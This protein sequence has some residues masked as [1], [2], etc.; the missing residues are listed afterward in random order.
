MQILAWIQ[1]E[2]TYAR[3]MTHTVAR[4]VSDEDGAAYTQACLYPDGT[5]V[6]CA[7]VIGLADGLISEQTIVQVW[8]E[9]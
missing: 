7:T 4:R 5:N 9:R 8:D 2:D 1:T 3:D 6:L